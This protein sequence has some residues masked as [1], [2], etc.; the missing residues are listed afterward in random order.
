MIVAHDGG[1]LD[2]D[3]VS[4]EIAKT[5]RAL[6]AMNGSSSMS[7]L[8][9]GATSPKY[10]VVGLS[11]CRSPS[12]DISYFPYQARV[13]RVRFSTQKNRISVTSISSEDFNNPERKSSTNSQKDPNKPN[14]GT[15]TIY[16]CFSLLPF[17]KVLASGYMLPGSHVPSSYTI[18]D[19]CSHNAMVAKQVDRLDLVQVWTLL[20]MSAKGCEET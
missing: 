3:K 15:V 10:S 14:L 1:D 8:G 17:S 18:S 20:S 6:S 5:P 7:L 9:S 16:S 13:P 19:I 11:L 12:Q 4:A 2:N